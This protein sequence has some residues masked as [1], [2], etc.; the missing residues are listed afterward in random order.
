MTVDDEAAPDDEHP[1]SGRDDRSGS[2][3]AE[4][5]AALGP[6]DLAIRDHV[7]EIGRD[8]HP[9]R[10]GQPD[11]VDVVQLMEDTREPGGPGDPDRSAEREASTDQD[12]QSVLRGMALEMREGTEESLELHLGRIGRGDRS[13]DPRS[14]RPGSGAG[15]ARCATW[16]SRSTRRP[17]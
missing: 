1:E 3:D 4:A 10:D 9:E 7:A 16:R 15:R 2:P 12:E 11:R 6:G 8:L 13:D 5:R 14:V 17:R